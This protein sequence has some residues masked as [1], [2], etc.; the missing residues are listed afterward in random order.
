MWN[1]T[2]DPAYAT[3]VKVEMPGLRTQNGL[4]STEKNLYPKRR[5]HYC[6]PII[7]IIF[8]SLYTLPKTNGSLLITSRLEIVTF[9]SD[10]VSVKWYLKVN[11]SDPNIR[12]VMIIPEDVIKGNLSAAGVFQI[13]KES[14]QL[15]N[16]TTFLIEGP[17]PLGILSDDFPNDKYEANYF[18]GCNFLSQN[19]SIGL[20]GSI[21]GPN[22]NYQASWSLSIDTNFT[23]RLHEIPAF[24]LNDIG[25][26]TC[27]LKLNLSI[28]HRP[29][30]PTF[31][32]V[33]VNQV[34]LW[35]GIFGC[36]LAVAVF[37]SICYDLA[38]SRSRKSKRLTMIEGVVVPISA[39][40]IVFIPVYLLAL[41]TFEAP[42]M[43]IKAENKLVDLLY[44]YLA[45]L[46]IGTV[47][48]VVFSTPD[49]PQNKPDSSQP[50]KDNGSKAKSHLGAVKNNE[51]ISSE[52]RMRVQRLISELSSREN[53]T[54]IVSTIAASASLAILA[55]AT[56]HGNAPPFDSTFL[57]G[58]AFSFIG[59]IYR[60]VTVFFVDLQD[61]RSLNLNARPL[62]SSDRSRKIAV[63]SRMFIIRFL[64]LMPIAAWL[65]VGLP[66]EIQGSTWAVSITL[67]CGV[68]FT[69]SLV[70]H[71][72][73]SD[74]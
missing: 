65:E 23:S 35:L 31:V 8:A 64:L 26:M 30:F 68:A 70:E 49:A 41:H 6:F 28:F 63:F 9:W 52:E 72:M 57:I 27:W 17:I 56:Q 24:A 29:P 58:I 5:L 61:Y 74:P 4:A 36:I 15:T 14:D 46:V 22:D 43:M 66:Q 16:Y 62:T 39:A 59:F 47:F 11:L 53:S 42:L 2:L 12:M 67:L 7:L 60:E 51:N 69:L 38:R 13:D 34:P 37:P 1:A 50:M 54:L 48:R 71:H 55:V 18:I 3:W 10:F 20:G 19:S 25:N 32:G 73:R 33:L 21:P 44:L 45:I 40:V